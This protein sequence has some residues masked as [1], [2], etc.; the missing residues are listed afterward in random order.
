MVKFEIDCSD[1]IN[2][3]IILSILAA[4]IAILVLYIDK[5]IFIKT[6]DQINYISYIKM[7]ILVFITTFF[8]LFIKEKLNYENINID[9]DN[10]EIELAHEVPF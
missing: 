1:I 2:N 9:D 7:F 6:D 8:I 10:T 4:L 5:C 3:N